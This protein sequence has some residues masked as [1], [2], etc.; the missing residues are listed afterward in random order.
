MLSQTSIQVKSETDSSQGRKAGESEAEC[1]VSHILQRFGGQYWL[2]KSHRITSRMLLWNDYSECGDYRFVMAS[3]VTTSMIWRI[4][5]A[6]QAEV[7]TEAWQSLEFTADSPPFPSK[8][9]PSRLWCRE[10]C[11]A[12]LNR[13]TKTGHVPRD[14]ENL[15]ELDIFFLEFSVTFD[16]H[17]SI[18]KEINVDSESWIEPVALVHTSLTQSTSIALSFA[19]SMPNQNMVVIPWRLGLDGYLTPKAGRISH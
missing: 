16:V 7:A 6:T 14:Y 4:S 8:A 12:H 5:F 1:R 17:N 15:R 3:K 13:S 18:Y 10:L 9:G 19:N 11:T 2:W